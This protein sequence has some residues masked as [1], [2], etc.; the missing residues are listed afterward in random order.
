MCTTKDKMFNMKKV[1]E[2]VS[3]GDGK[4][5]TI[6]YMGEVIGTVKKSDGSQNSLHLKDV[7]IREEKVMP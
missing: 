3:V 4:R 1:S 6:D 2:V 7:A 5:I